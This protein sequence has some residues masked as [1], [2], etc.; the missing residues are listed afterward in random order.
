MRYDL[1]NPQVLAYIGD[2]VYELA[3]REYIVRH[4]G[5]LKPGEFLNIKVK[6][7]TAKAHKEFMYY[8]ID[9]DLF[10][11][12]ELSLYRRGRNGKG[13]RNESKDHKHSTGFEAIIGFHHL[14]GNDIRVKEIINQA[15]T[16]FNETKT[17][18]EQ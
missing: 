5:V 17:E 4:S 3:I 15:I 18:Q 12:H 16:Y 14:D 11:E 1:M 9:N 13:N 2:A 7:V 8:A 10:T 6:Y